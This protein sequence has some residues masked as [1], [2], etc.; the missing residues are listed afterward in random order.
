MKKTFLLGGLLLGLTACGGGTTTPDTS[1][2]YNP[3]ASVTQSTD[4]RTPY[5]GDWVFVA[6]LADNTK[7]YGVAAITDKYSDNSVKNAGGG[8]MA[9]CLRSDCTQDDEQGTGLIGSVSVQTGAALAIGM[10]PEKASATRFVMTDTDGRVETKD[11]KAMIMGEGT[12]TNTAG[13]DQAANF[14]FVQVN[15]QSDLASQAVKQ[16]ALLNA[17]ALLTERSLAPLKTSLPEV[18]AALTERLLK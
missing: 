10:V 18:R 3:N 17:Q 8:F 16:Q 5:R 1:Y 15:T 6:I 11:G 4:A 2:P 13:G 9:W 12:W 7:R 14:V